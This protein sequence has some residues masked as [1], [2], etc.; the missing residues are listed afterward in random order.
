MPPEISGGFFCK[1]LGIK[2]AEPGILI[3]NR[4]RMAGEG[5][6]K[7]KENNIVQNRNNTNC[8]V[9][10]TSIGGQRL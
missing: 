3:V 10:E 8:F 2:Q 4:N 6:L 9:F 7:N 5:I 1:V